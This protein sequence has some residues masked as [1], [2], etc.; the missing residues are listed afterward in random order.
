MSDEAKTDEAPKEPK[1]TVGSI[2]IAS[3]KAG[4]TNEEALADVKEAIPTAKT[5]VASVNWYR[6][7]LRSEKAL[8]DD[9]ELVPTMRDLNKKAAAATE[10]D[11]AGEK[12]EGE[13]F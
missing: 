5:T 7:K 1:V 3:I 12:P 4:K 11:G 8:G 2:A 10:T 9:G 13:D 6:Q